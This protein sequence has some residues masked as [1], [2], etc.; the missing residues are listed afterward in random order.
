MLS[1]LSF[2]L[3][4]FLLLPTGNLGCRARAG[5]LL[6]AG[7]LS[8]VTIDG[9]SLA[10]YTRSY[11]DDLALT[12]VLWLICLG[13]GRVM[14]RPLVSRNNQLQL[15]AC[16]VV[17]G[18]VLYPATLGMSLVDPYRFGFSPRP[19]LL[20]VGVACVAWWYLRNHFAVALL[21]FATAMFLLDIKTSDNYW[22]YLIDPLLW[23]AS[24]GYLLKH[25]YRRWWRLRKVGFAKR[26]AWLPEF[27]GVLD[28]RRE[29]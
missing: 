12:T 11:A 21:T 4:V 22:D 18:F 9:L 2:M 20:A 25:G 13:V 26:P 14:R 29:M 23:L 3:L 27:G 10:D 5:L 1:H 6:L 8:F 17:L 15:A 19:L 24:C 28:V 16:F 7:A